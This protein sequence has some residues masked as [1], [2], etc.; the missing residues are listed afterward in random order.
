M[1]NNH[2]ISELEQRISTLEAKGKASRLKSIF[3]GFFRNKSLEETAKNITESS[4]DASKLLSG[5]VEKLKIQLPKLDELMDIVGLKKHL[6]EKQMIMPDISELKKIPAIEF[7]NLQEIKKIKVEFKTP[8]I[9]D[10][11]NLDEVFESQSKMIIEMVERQKEAVRA[12]AKEY[13][14]ERQRRK[15]KP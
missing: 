13:F 14:T 15:S 3:G 9:F 4:P 2:K 12:T 7:A 8:I 1:D 6:E 5:A 11:L 10:Q